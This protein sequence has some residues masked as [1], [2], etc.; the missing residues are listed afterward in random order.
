MVSDSRH[1]ADRGALA[2]G[3]AALL[4]PALALAGAGGFALQRA[5]FSNAASAADRA[6]VAVRSCPGQQVVGELHGGDR[7]FV[8]GISAKPTGWLL[9]RN[10]QQ[11][12][13][14]WWIDSRFVNTDSPVS[15]LPT[16]SC[17]HQVPLA[18]GGTSGIA[19][20]S[21]PASTSRAAA[22]TGSARRSASGSPP[23]TA[24]PR[25][26]HPATTPAPTSRHGGAP[27]TPA[28]T[29]PATTASSSP[30]TTAPPST[31]KSTPDPSPTPAPILGAATAKPTDIWEVDS[32][33][34][35]TNSPGEPTS[36]EISVMA[37]DASQV[38]L[39]WNVGPTPRSEAMQ[40][41]GDTW[42]AVLGPFH[43][44]TVSSPTQIVV[45]VVAT[46]PGGSTRA[47]T[48]VTLNNCV[49]FG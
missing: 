24:R 47:S 18:A 27:S 20:V 4:V 13:E 49:S 3:F 45:S 25:S 11:P 16:V 12:S 34:T 38:T 43:Q 36:S 15:G 9:I 37:Q 8:I 2:A 40:R 35:C 48:T 14:H 39:S 46:G 33:S 17:G 32:G 6:Q 26:P 23:S 5:L 22:P 1:G 44:G 28:T 42:T 19:T 30:G 21:A 29:A 31:P 41:T 10:P 7:V